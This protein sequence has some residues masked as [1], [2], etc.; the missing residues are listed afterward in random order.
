M[1]TG[2]RGF[3]RPVLPLLHRNKWDGGRRS[4]ALRADRSRVPGVP[5][6][7]AVWRKARP[8]TASGRCER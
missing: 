5:A 3:R 1:S 2:C 4:S 7:Q 6:R 8:G